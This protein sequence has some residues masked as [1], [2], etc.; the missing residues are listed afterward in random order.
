MPAAVGSLGPKEADAAAD[1]FQVASDGLD[2]FAR[3]LKALMRAYRDAPE[4]GPAPVELRRAKAELG[5]ALGPLEPYAALIR[6][7][8]GIDAEALALRQL[9]MLFEAPGREYGTFPGLLPMLARVARAS[10]TTGAD[11]GLYTEASAAAQLAY[12]YG[13]LAERLTG[14]FDMDAAY[15][16][17]L[18]AA[19]VAWNDACRG[20]PPTRPRRRRMV[21]DAFK[22]MSI[23][24]GND[25]GADLAL[26]VG[27]RDLWNA[28]SKLMRLN[29]A[30][31]TF[32]HVLFHA[33]GLGRRGLELFR[34][35][36]PALFALN[37][38]AAPFEGAAERLRGEAIRLRSVATLARG[39]E[40]SA[41]DGARNAAADARAAYVAL[42]TGDGFCARLA[43]ALPGTGSSVP[44][45]PAGIEGF[46][47]D[48]PELAESFGA[49]SRDLFRLTG[50]GGRGGPL[51]TA[52]ASDCAR[53]ALALAPRL[54]ECRSYAAAAAEARRLG[55]GRF[56]EALERGTL[57]PDSAGPALAKAVN[58]SFLD[59]AIAGRRRLK[60]FDAQDRAGSIAR[61]REYHTAKLAAAAS[62]T[63]ARLRP[64][65]WSSTI[66]QAEIRLLNK[67]SGKRSGRMPVRELLSALPNLALKARPCFLMSPLSVSQF[68]AAGCQRF[69]LVI[70]DEASQIPVWDAAGSIARGGAVV[71][72]GD[73]QQLPPTSFFMRSAN[74]DADDLL[75]EAPL[76]S[77][78]DE[79]L[80]A[81]VPQVKLLW[82]YRSRSESLISFSNDR[83]YGGELVTFPSPASWDRAVS[84][85]HVGN[86][87]YGRGKSRTN[88]REAEAVVEEVLKVLR[89]NQDSPDPLSVGVVTFNRQQQEL[90]EDL[91][92][93]AWHTEPALGRFF[94]EGAGAHKASGKAKPPAKGGGGMADGAGDPARG[95]APAGPEASDPAASERPGGPAY[96]G[97]REPVMVKSLENIQGD[98]RDIMIFSVGYGPDAKGELHLNFGPLNGE[99]G[100]RRL[101]VAVTRARREVRVFASFMPSEMGNCSGG[102]ADLKAYM[103]YALQKS[104]ARAAGIVRARPGSFAATVAAALESRGWRTSAGVGA[105]ERVM[106]LAVLDPDDPGRFLAGIEGDGGSYMEA[107]TAVDREVL[108]PQVL[109]GMG[110]EILR[111]WA[112]QWLKDPEGEASRL[113]AALKAALARHRAGKGRPEVPGGTENGVSNAEVL[114]DAV[115]T[116]AVHTAVRRL[117]PVPAGLLCRQVARSLGR[118]P[119][120]ELS[121]RILAIGRRKFATT[122]ERSA[123]PPRTGKTEF[124][125]EEVPGKVLEF[126]K[127]RPGGN[128]GEGDWAADV[129]E[130]AFSELVALASE[131]SPG[132]GEDPLEIMG[133]AL[134]LYRLGS[135]SRGRLKA[136]WDESVLQGGPRAASGTGMA[137]GEEGRL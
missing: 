91:L 133:A 11:A 128:G 92:D 72:A 3:A 122:V 4:E 5:E 30:D 95:S 81:G 136:A 88:P 42:C 124:F 51:P 120:R 50:R 73:P 34:W 55:L 70:F 60:G 26:L 18:E 39:N 112:P 56:V 29:A 14:W 118:L 87:V 49:V 105:S 69:D 1:V 16:L 15:A 23:R 117:G 8:A 7:R 43:R 28:A 134:G 104:G 44:V 47:R 74:E 125:W 80:E 68:L 62:E 135:A 82:H 106:D 63:A 98:E 89:K 40:R 67:E 114:S 38:A 113:D 97:E 71:A 9:G 58:S 78:L 35:A 57:A 75:D 66:P 121:E 54:D 129:F 83:Y 17:D 108:R 48:F 85:R 119:G 130:V 61:F 27:M 76:E 96:D 79:L 20:F 46:L 21:K 37:G 111:V 45:V 52:R 25:F 107:T 24:E 103:E 32:A 36:L 13:A 127:R 94:V 77:V 99:G 65:G 6:D 116:D 93:R 110:W 10:G 12:E 109:A 33:T 102:A 22:R 132:P 115:L 41:L 123:P 2:A 59:S 64:E 19:T 84:F 126:R 100:K 101:N 137:S 31:P 86:A 53:E 131:I 90:I